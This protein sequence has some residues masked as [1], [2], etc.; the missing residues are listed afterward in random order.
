MAR[1]RKLGY[2][3]GI[4]EKFN[5][6]TKQRLDL[7]GCIDLVAIHPGHHGVL[8]VQATSA[9]N[10]ASRRAKVLASPIVHLWLT[11]GNRIWVVGWSKMGARG[12]PKRWTMTGDKVTLEDFV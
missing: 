10:L 3:V 5:S 2:T 1:L 12:K 4:V 6:F 8:G 11:A 9:A 7:F